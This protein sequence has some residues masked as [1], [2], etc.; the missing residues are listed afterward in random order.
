MSRIGQ[1]LAAVP[2]QELIT[3]LG[4]GIAK[5]QFELD[6]N[7]TKIAQLM[8]GQD[9]KDR[10][11]FGTDDKGKPRML[12]LI[13]LGFTPTFY[14]FVE[15]IIEVKIAVNMT[16]SSSYTRNTKTKK[17]DVETTGWG[18]WSSDKVVSTTTVDAKYSQKYDYSVEGS[19]SIRTKL[20]PVPPPAILEERIRAEMEK[21]A[22]K[23]AK[24]SN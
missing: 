6:K 20:V 3:N 17:D 18:W 16:T 5:A 10:V 11:A 15:S 8:S 13:E 22:E 19:T 21:E 4:L 1:E 12:S 14:Q 2:I 9:P 24:A 23:K 7:S